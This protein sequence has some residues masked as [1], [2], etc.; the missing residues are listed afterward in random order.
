MP[1]ITGP[2]LDSSGRPASGI[3][4]ARTTRPFDVDDGHVS[5][6][7]GVAEVRGGTPFAGTAPWSLPT[8]PEGVFLTLEQELDGELLKTFTVSVPDVASLTYSELLFNRGVGGTAAVYWWDLTG[9]ID[10]PP[11][12]I[13]G[14]YGYDSADGTIWRYEA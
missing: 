3:L 10:F 12:A 14:D 11:T 2:I 4:R 8:T 7:V 6:A 9:G 13:E 5:Q 1:T